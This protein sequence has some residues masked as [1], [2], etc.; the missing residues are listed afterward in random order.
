MLESPIPAVEDQETNEGP[1]LAI[2]PAQVSRLLEQSV[3]ALGGEY[4]PGQEQM[5]HEVAEAFTT[6]RHLLVQAGTGTGKSLAYLI[7]AM[8]AAQQTKKPVIVATATLALQSQLVG[9]DL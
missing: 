8:L 7:P 4:R 9:R 2:D 6:G 1:P 5:A 3:A